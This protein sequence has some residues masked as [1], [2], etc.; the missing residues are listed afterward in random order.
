MSDERDKAIP[1]KIVRMHWS[2]PVAG[3]GIVV[4]TT[5]VLAVASGPPATRTV[6]LAGLSL[7]FLAGLVLLGMLVLD[8]FLRLP[9]TFP[10]GLDDQKPEISRIRKVLHRIRD[11]RLPRE[12]SSVSTRESNESE[13]DLE[14]R[15]H[16]DRQVRMYLQ[17]TARAVRQGSGESNVSAF[18]R[19]T[20]EE[21][22]STA[23]NPPPSRM[24]PSRRHPRAA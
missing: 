22:T 6:L 11:L 12:R 15:R 18:R 13:A 8:P 10:H 20:D 21:D 9:G 5:V 14:A 17:R 3:A 2:V 16:L 19:G 24:P 1:F 23:T 7:L 4:A